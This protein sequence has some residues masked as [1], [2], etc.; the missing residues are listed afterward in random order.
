MKVVSPARIQTLWERAQSF[1]ARENGL[2]ILKDSVKFWR[3]WELEEQ[4]DAM[5]DDCYEEVHICGLRYAPSFALQNVDPIA[6]R[7]EYLNWLDSEGFTEIGG[8]YFE[9]TP[10][11]DF[12]DEQ[13]EID[14]EESE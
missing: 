8:F 3:E 4:F 2:D 12:L 14:E 6:Y 13:D 9:D 5:L 11:E 10:L 7:E 1:T